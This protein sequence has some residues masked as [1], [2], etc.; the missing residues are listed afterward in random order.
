MGLAEGGISRIT[1]FRSGVAADAAPCPSVRSLKTAVIGRGGGPSGTGID[2]VVVF[3]E[4]ATVSVVQQLVR[5][6]KFKSTAP[7]GPHSVAISVSDGDGLKSN[8]EV[9]TVNVS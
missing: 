5:A 1:R 9:M 2:M 4:N 6:L 3:N 8:V 7:V